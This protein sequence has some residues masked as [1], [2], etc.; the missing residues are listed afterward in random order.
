MEADP[1]EI[2]LISNKTQS[3]YTNHEKATNKAKFTPPKLPVWEELDKD[4]PDYQS[5]FDARTIKMRDYF[6]K[7]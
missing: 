7:Y 6:L 1:G 5:K 3:D 4:D 2:L